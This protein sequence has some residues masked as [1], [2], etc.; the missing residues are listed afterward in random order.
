MGI[1]FANNVAGILR[2]PIG[3]TDA[4]IPLN[5]GNG[6][7]FPS[8]AADEYFYATLVHPTTG[9]VEIISVTG[10]AGDNL[11]ADRGR[12]GTI[13][14]TFPAGTYVEMRL[15]AQVLRDLDPL[16]YRGQADGLAP[17]DSTQRLPVAN[18]PT[19]A[20]TETSGDARYPRLTTRNEPNGY[21]GLNS[22]AKLPVSMIE[23]LNLDLYAL[24]AGCDMTGQL[25]W[26]NVDRAV[27]INGPANPPAMFFVKG[28]ADVRFGNGDLVFENVLG[29]V[30]GTISATGNTLRLQ[31]ASTT[32]SDVEISRNFVPYLLLDPD[33]LRILKPLVL[34]AVGANIGGAV[35]I[36]S[37]LGVTGL[38]TVAELTIGDGA[39]R[40]KLTVSTSAPTG[41]PVDGEE[42]YQIEA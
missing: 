30:Q 11:T 35:T 40:A 23:G 5:S 3:P 28:K 32:D 21:A 4:T 39:K 27:N 18:L 19:T 22:N 33:E 8:P 38:A 41:T 29:S 26:V 10:R 12:D 9:A 13:A 15:V 34:D 20:L 36:A 24:K 14:Q 25:R 2:S 42:W 31:I 1:L 7:S 17:L 16:S 6:V 37:T